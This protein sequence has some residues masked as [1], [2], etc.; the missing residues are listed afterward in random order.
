MLILDVGIHASQIIALHV[1]KLAAVHAFQMVMTTAAVLLVHELITGALAALDVVPAHRAL[2][3]QPVQIPVYRSLPHHIFFPVQEKND[4]IRGE[5]MVFILYQ[6]LQDL[7][8]LA[9]L[10]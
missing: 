10:I 8:S 1:D 7:I 9:R 4:L 3:Y 2:R 5:M 6:I